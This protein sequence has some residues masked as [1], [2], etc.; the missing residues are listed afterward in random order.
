[1]GEQQPPPTAHSTGKIRAQP[2]ERSR[3]VRTAHSKMPKATTSRTKIRCCSTS[4]C[5]KPSQNPCGPSG[6]AP[7]SFLIS[8]NTASPRKRRGQWRAQRPRRP[9]RRRGRPWR[10]RRSRRSGGCTR[11]TPGRHRSAARAGR[12]PACRRWRGEL[13]E[14]IRG[15]K[16]VATS[17][18]VARSRTT[19]TAGGSEVS[20]AAANST[21]SPS[22]SSTS[23]KRLQTQG[24]D[25]V[26]VAKTADGG[27]VQR[28]EHEET[29]ENHHLGREHHAV[30]RP[31]QRGEP[32][33]VVQGEAQA[34]RH[35]DGH[36]RQRQ[37]REAAQGLGGP[38]SPRP[39]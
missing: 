22:P 24:Q 2:G 25:V 31:D 1:M 3:P 15:V 32:V 30:G 20:D 11:T 39:C 36:R 12:R 7:G 34:R 17:A 29:S 23:T 27:E 38:R 33:D 37:R 26:G 35:Q 14:G 13:R 21:V 9:G 16:R 19:S 8:R 18:S 6:Q 28:A 10:E 5:A 4:G